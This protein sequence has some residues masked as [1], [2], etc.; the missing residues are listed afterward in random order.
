MSD[1]SV[2]KGWMIWIKA[3]REPRTI[4]NAANWMYRL[5]VFARQKGRHAI[6][7]QVYALKNDLIRYLYQHGYATEVLLHEQ[8]RICYA[9][10][11]TGEHWT[12]G[13]CFKCDGTGVFS[14]TGLYAFRFLV[15]GRVYKW[16]QL[17]KYVNYPIA[18]TNPKSSPFVAPPERD[19][20]SLK[21]EEAWF[22]CCAV[23]WTLLA[24]GIVS[25]LRLFS[26]TRERVRLFFAR[27]AFA[28]RLR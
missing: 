17:M 18:L 22:G 20:V 3:L 10:D 12:G 1:V 21:M 9:C 13:E 14:V 24:H 8:K 5:N 7:D 28:I 4:A 25:D 15:D 16:H 27:I 6:V 19:D 23:W 26:A 11:G 2:S